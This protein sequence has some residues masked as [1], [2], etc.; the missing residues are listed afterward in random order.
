M[1]G[2]LPQG[3]YEEG[4]VSV[5]DRDVLV[6]YSDGLLE[7]ANQADVEFGEERLLAAVKANWDRSAAAIRRE[8]LGA[9]NAFIGP[10]ELQDD[11]TLLVARVGPH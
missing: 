8:I 4:Q 10:C 11:L 6:L 3:A 5:N 2:L 1:L 7:A 9:V